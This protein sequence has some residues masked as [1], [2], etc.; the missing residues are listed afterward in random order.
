[1]RSL[2]YII[3]LMSLI[4]NC[5]SEKASC[6]VNSFGKVCENNQNKQLPTNL[7]SSHFKEF[8]RFF[9]NSLFKFK[10]DNLFNNHTFPTE[11]LHS[12]KVIA[13]ER[14][15][16]LHF[17]S[18]RSFIKYKISKIRNKDYLE[19]SVLKTNS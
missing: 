4:A 17:L 19:L 16:D 12:I 15:F 8:N 9:S 1:M 13:F 10:Q 3:I 11:D 7:T 6:V 18:S 5:Q 2:S 14:N